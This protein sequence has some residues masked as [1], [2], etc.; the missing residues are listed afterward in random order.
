MIKLRDVLECSKSEVIIMDGITTESMC[1]CNR[2]DYEKYVCA[3]LLETRI[4]YIRACG[5]SIRV[6]LD[7]EEDI[8]N[9]H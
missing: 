5:A 4:K 7:D 3:I 1:I 2:I 9:E 8:V 6:W